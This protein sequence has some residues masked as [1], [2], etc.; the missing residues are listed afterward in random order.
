M[1]ISAFIYSGVVGAV[2]IVG[3]LIILLT[4]Q[5]NKKKAM[6]LDSRTFFGVGILWLVMGVPLQNSGLLL[7]G[8]VFLAL[9][10]ADK[11]AWI[12][13]KPFVA[14]V[15]KGQSIKYLVLLV[16]VLALILSLVTVISF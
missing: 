12:H 3:L 10:I 9:G 14:H 7:L 13:P 11:Q 1:E 15:K 6:E 5:K 16:A 4:A 8:L 2:V